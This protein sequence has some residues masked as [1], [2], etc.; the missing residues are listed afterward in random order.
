MIGWK[1][2]WHILVDALG[3]DSYQEIANWL[4]LPDSSFNN[5]NNLFFNLSDTLIVS[6]ITMEEYLLCE[7]L[8]MYPFLDRRGTARWNFFD[9]LT[10][11]EFFSTTRFTKEGARR[12]TNL[13]EPHL[14]S[15]TQ[16]GKPLSPLEQ[17][18]IMQGF[19]LINLLMLN[20]IRTLQ[21]FKQI[22]L[23]MKFYYQPLISVWINLVNTAI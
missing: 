1:C 2:T 10:N 9:E 5:G 22:K 15:E 8:E 6:V 20:K 19:L 3:R 23:S 11:E 12:L 21:L 16:R 4:A 7:E 18:M 13:L 17:V 14:S